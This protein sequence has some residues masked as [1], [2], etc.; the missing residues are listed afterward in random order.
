MGRCHLPESELLGRHRPDAGAGGGRNGHAVSYQPLGGRFCNGPPVVNPFF[1]AIPL[2]GSC[3]CTGS[4]LGRRLMVSEKEGAGQSYWRGCFAVASTACGRC[5]LTQSIVPAGTPLPEGWCLSCPKT[6]DC[7]SFYAAAATLSQVFAAPKLVPSASMR[8][9][10]T[11]SF[12]A[13]ATFAFFIPA[14]CAIFA[15]QLFR[16]PPLIGLVRMT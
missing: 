4:A 3:F 12:L 8:C 2:P 16:L 14:R 7:F 6:L 13:S 5:G 15:A 9:R 11:A 1:C 10:I